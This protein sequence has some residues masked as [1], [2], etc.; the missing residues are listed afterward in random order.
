MYWVCKQPCIL[1]DLNKNI[2][3]PSNLAKINKSAKL[4]AI[5]REQERNKDKMKAKNKSIQSNDF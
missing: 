4:K 3:N 1:P 2:R 5:G